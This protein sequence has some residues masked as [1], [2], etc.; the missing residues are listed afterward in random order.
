LNLPTRKSGL[1]SKDGQGSAFRILL[2][3]VIVQEP[4]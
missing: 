1:T 4:N 3:S 2:N